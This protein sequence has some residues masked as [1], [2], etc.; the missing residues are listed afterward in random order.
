MATSPHI[1]PSLA[2]S[3][4]E[5]REMV[6]SADITEIYKLLLDHPTLFLRYLHFSALSCT[7][8]RQE[9]LLKQT[10]EELDMAFHDMTDNDFYDAFAFFIA[11]KQ[12][13]Q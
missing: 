3:S 9:L 4:L 6:T 10:K 7:L 2:V 13:E 1:S 5:F 12:N 11:R 8:K